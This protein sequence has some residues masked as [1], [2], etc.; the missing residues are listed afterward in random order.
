MSV[1]TAAD[2]FQRVRVMPNDIGGEGNL[3]GE[4][5]SFEPTIANNGDDLVI[6]PSRLHALLE[7]LCRFTVVA[8]EVETLG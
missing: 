6:R 3:V 5:T 1:T 2:E 4:R 7:D 8:D